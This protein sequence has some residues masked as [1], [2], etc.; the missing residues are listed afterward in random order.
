M[1]VEAAGREYEF[2]IVGAGALGSILGAHL[3]RAGHSVA[4]LARG[5]RADWIQREGL[6]ITGL[7]EIS[8]PA[9]VFRDPAELRSADTLIVATKTPG[10]EAVLAK[11]RHV[12][13]GTAFSIQNGPVKDELLAA[14]FGA[15]RVLGALADTSGEMLSSGEVLFTRNVN[16]LL[17]ELTGETGARAREIAA[18]IDSSGVR[19]T[20]VSD[21]VSLEWS[22][23]VIWV[24]MV[25]L[26]V[27]VRSVTWHYL[28]DP[29]SAVVLV[30]LTREM[31][32]L[33]DTL[34]IKLT[35]HAVLP[36][37]SLCS[38]SEEDAVAL[39]TR[40]GR[41]FKERAPEHRMSS[42]QD[43]EAGRP[44]EIHETLGYALRKAAGRGVPMPLLDAFYGVISTAERVRLGAS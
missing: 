19:A 1:R 14:A 10:T 22:K 44:L 9:R 36:A 6:R 12:H 8:T 38:G 13:I 17:G 28:S 21:I 2:V 18:T 34:G 15:S 4:L 32:R 43:L 41:E 7:L 20:A 39:V 33:A 25:V 23:F 5:Q 30:R 16:I 26:S 24:G 37:A 11:L 35:D 40:A 29:A 31:A 3:A 42:L 27:T